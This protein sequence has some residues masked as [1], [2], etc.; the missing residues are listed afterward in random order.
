MNAAA[1]GPPLTDA[2][3]SAVRLATGYD[4]RANIS[5]REV[6]G[7]A[8]KLDV[9]RPVG[10]AERPTLVFFHAG[11]W[12]DGATKE[13]WAHWFL[14]FLHLGWIV[15]NVGYRPSSVSPAPAAV[16]DCLYA[17]RWIGQ[18]ADEFRMDVTQLV[19]AGLSA[20]GH[21]ALMTGMTPASTHELRQ[22]G[23]NA[24]AR[25]L[26]PELINDASA[27]VKPAAIVSWCGIADV[28]DLIS[29]SNTREYAIRWIG[30]RPDAQ[31]IARAMSPLSYVRSGVPPVVTVHGDNDASVPYS[32]A[33]RLHEALTKAGVTNQLIT[34]CGA[35]H[36][37][38]PEALL[39]TYP[40]VLSFLAQAG[41]T[42][43]PP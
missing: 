37:L 29:G 32:Q 10:T 34:A 40:R 14:P 4:V 18:H 27:L 8:V 19:L 17:L 12:G 28:A 15:V 7:F 20:G 5:Y 30:D 35:G 38:G 33:V 41:V 24:G 43:E 31:A 23:S 42:V 22:S 21:L 39:A 25:V 9:Y 26:T 6:G 2:I 13:T 16:Q 11:G 1:A 3:A 36:A